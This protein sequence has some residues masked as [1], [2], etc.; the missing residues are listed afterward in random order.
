MLYLLSPRQKFKPIFNY[1]QSL[2]YYD[3]FYTQKKLK[4]EELRIVIMLPDL[5]QLEAL[6]KQDFIYSHGP[7]LISQK[8]QTILQKEFELGLVQF[9]EAEIDGFGVLDTHVALH[10][11]NIEPVADLEKSTFEYDPFRDEYEFEVLVLKQAFEWDLTIARGIGAEIHIFINEAL[12][13]RL[14]EGGVKKGLVLYTI[15]NPFRP[16]EGEFIKI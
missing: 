5:N 15:Y 14:V 11:V 13:Q 10:V 3:F 16:S 12:K 9:F 4:Q 2:N 6:T 1:E 8:I 7:L